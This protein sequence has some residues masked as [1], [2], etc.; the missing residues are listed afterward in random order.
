MADQLTIDELLQTTR[1]VRKRLDFDRPLDLEVVHECLELALQA[2]SGSNAQGWHFV[3]VTDS[4]KRQRIG[5]LYAQAFDAYRGMPISAHALADRAEGTDRKVMDQV[6]TS[7][8]YLAANLARTPAL[9]IPC[10]EGRC[11]GVTGALA[12]LSQAGLYGSILPALWSFMLAAR[13]RGIGTS[14]TTLHLMYE[15]E[16][17][18]LLG[19]PYDTVTQAAL[20]PVAYYQ[21]TT[22]KPA[23]RKP[24]QEVL[25]TNSW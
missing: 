3:L 25:H 8:E 9:L 21:G 4:D 15:K 22:F 13:S 7:A 17:A 11:D 12:S 10:V 1:A 20:S 14:W 18:E 5:E 24:L 19:I 23:T 6:V 16:V 2:P